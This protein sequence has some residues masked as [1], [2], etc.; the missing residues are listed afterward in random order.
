MASEHITADMVEATEFPHLVMKYGVQ[1]VPHTVI[2][3]KIT[4]VGSVPE[5]EFARKVLEAVGKSSGH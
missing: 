3:E 2:N 4:V 5:M 1:G